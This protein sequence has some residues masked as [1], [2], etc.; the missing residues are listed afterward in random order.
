M[1]LGLGKDQTRHD[2]EMADVRPTIDNDTRVVADSSEVLERAFDGVE[3]VRGAAGY[4]VRGLCNGGFHQGFEAHSTL[5]ASGVA[6]R[7]GTAPQRQVLQPPPYVRSCGL[8]ASD[9]AL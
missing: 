5:L 7:Q 1:K 4:P 3:A 6:A 9:R 2:A 8:Q